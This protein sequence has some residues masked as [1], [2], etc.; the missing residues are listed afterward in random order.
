MAATTFQDDWRI[1]A[2]MTNSITIGNIIFVRT[3]GHTTRREDLFLFEGR[4]IDK[5][6]LLRMDIHFFVFYDHHHEFFY[7]LQ[8]F[9][10]VKEAANE[11]GFDINL[12]EPKAI[13]GNFV[14][15]DEE[16]QTFLKLSGKIV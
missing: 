11:A 10:W 7:I 1:Y 4:F 6:H 5:T 13:F 8:N 15:P 14:V 16:T 2:N 3:D 9:D 12:E